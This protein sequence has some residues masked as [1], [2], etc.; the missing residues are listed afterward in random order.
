MEPQLGMVME[1]YSKGSLYDLMVKGR[2][3]QFD[4]KVFFALSKQICAGLKAM[5]SHKPQILHRDLKSLNIL[6]ND[7]GQSVLADFG[8]LKLN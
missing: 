4:W 1:Y 7:N 8:N 6:V 5:H 3:F 2:N